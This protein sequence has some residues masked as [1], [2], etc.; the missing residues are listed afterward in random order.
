[1]SCVYLQARDIYEEAV[2]T[3]LTARDFSQ[4]F[5]AYAQFEETMISARMEAINEQGLTEDSEYLLDDR[6]HRKE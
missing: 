2:Q 3:V 1:M 4:V 5:D 6:S